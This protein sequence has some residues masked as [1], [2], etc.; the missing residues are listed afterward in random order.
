MSKDDILLIYS[1]HS[2]TADRNDRYCNMNRGTAD[3]NR[4][5]ESVNSW[6]SET[7]A[8]HTCQNVGRTAVQSPVR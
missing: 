3:L 5:R 7:D 4:G 1:L 2:K 8:G 6:A